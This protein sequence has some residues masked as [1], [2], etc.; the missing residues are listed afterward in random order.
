VIILGIATSVLLNSEL[1][2]IVNESWV[3]LY[4]DLT[5]LLFGQNGL[6]QSVETIFLIVWL[7]LPLIIVFTLICSI[8]I[9][10]LGHQR[11]YLYSYLGAT[12]FVFFILNKLPIFNV[13]LPPLGG[14]RYYNVF[15]N[16]LLF[17]TLFFVFSMVIQK[18]NKK[19]NKD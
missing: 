2:T 8:L 5:V 1:L 13:L 7:Q 4:A 14:M 12:I 15:S 10:K 17:L 16:L 3:L 19:I 18:H 9:N 11:F 6:N